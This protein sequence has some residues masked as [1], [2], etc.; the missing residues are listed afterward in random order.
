[1]KQDNNTD[2]AQITINDV[3][4]L[5]EMTNEEFENATDEVQVKSL[6][7]INERNIAKNRDDVELI[8][9]MKAGAK[10]TTYSVDTRRVV[11]LYDIPNGFWYRVDDPQFGYSEI[12]DTKPPVDVYVM[13]VMEFV[14]HA[15]KNSS[16]EFDE[17][18][19]FTESKDNWSFT[20]LQESI[21]NELTVLTE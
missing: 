1:M 21:R 11:R 5:D 19:E 16:E 14:N 7:E 15:I 20:K 18:F 6:I 3:E 17:A 10:N 4:N 12:M 13:D 8:F 2:N 9:E